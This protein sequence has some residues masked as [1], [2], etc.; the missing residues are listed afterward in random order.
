M[1][2]GARFT[3]DY[4]NVL[5]FLTVTKIAYFWFKSCHTIAIPLNTKAW[6]AL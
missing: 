6:S 5:G 1:A 3:C 2:A 4:R